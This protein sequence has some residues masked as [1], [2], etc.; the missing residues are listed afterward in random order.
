MNARLCWSGAVV[1]Y[2]DHFSFSGGGRGF[3]TK[4]H[5]AS[6]LAARGDG[7]AAEDVH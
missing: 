7:D 2:I 1:V 6:A 5:R 3:W 4:V